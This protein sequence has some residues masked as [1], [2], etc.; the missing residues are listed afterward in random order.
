MP[1]SPSSP[2][3]PLSPEQ[4][5][6]SQFLESQPEAQISAPTE[7]GSRAATTSIAATEESC[8]GLTWE[9]GGEDKDHFEGVVW[10]RLS[11]FA[12]PVKRPTGRK[13]WIY[14]HGYRVVKRSDPKS[15]WFVCKYCHIH[16][17]FGGGLYDVTKATTAAVK[18]LKRPVTG[19][20]FSSDRD[21]KSA[22][23]AH[24]Q[25]SLQQAING[26]IKFSQHATN[27]LGYFNVQQFRL[28]F[29]LWIVDNNMPME[30]IA[31]QSTREMIK[32]AN[33]E[34]ERALWQSPRSVA[35]YAMRL[36]RQLKPHIVLA[37]S[38]AVSKIHVSFDGWTTKGGKRGFF[39]I[40]AH[41]ATAAGAVHDLP[42]SLPQLAGAHT[43]KLKIQSTQPS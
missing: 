30:I 31:R 36:F 43:G 35:T 26:G 18:H 38:D 20:G 6:E 22:V 12:K 29:V 15:V 33:P 19:H 10:E 37:L 7:H 25:L 42:I 9:D 23:I 16:K 28:A 40:V 32:F 27:A 41:F 34:A 4:P 1:S 21:V 24:G 2:S 39:G 3:S 5:W 14:D 8:G 11:R 13:S 17:A